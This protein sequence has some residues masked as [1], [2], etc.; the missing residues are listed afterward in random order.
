MEPGD[1]KHNQTIPRSRAVDEDVLTSIIAGL[2]IVS[3]VLMEKKMIKK[4]IDL[5]RKKYLKNQIIRK[6]IFLKMID[7]Q[8]N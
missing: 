6:E 2:S 4:E 8:M 5:M 3:Q 1:L 7:Q